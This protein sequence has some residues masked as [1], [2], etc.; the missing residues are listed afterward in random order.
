MAPQVD[1]TTLVLRP[2]LQR[3][4]IDFS[5]EVIRRGFYPKGGGEI[6]VTVQPNTTALPRPPVVL[7]DVGQITRIDGI[8]FG[9]GRVGAEI[10]DSARRI[11]KR[12][13]TQ[14]RG[15]P[16]DVQVRNFGPGSGVV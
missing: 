4:G 15:I 6:L 7:D 1:F 13:G 10:A 16:I 14:I 3:F 9:N 5:L 8:S 11:L 2:L 12:E